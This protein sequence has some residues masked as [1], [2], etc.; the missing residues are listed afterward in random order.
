[1]DDPK[2]QKYEPEAPTLVVEK[3]VSVASASGQSDPREQGFPAPAESSREFP[4][5]PNNVDGEAPT[6]AVTATGPSDAG[7]TLPPETPMHLAVNAA[8]AMNSGSALRPG[9]VLANRYEIIKT[10]GEGGMGAVYKA[11]DRELERDVALKVI[12]PELAN[13]PQILQRLS[14]S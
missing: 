5:T 4:R 12:K 3:S 11:H 8:A 7:V 10:L 6:L 1:M 13:D 2:E 9:T 14:R